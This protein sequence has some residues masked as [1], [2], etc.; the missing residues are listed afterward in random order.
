MPYG[1]LIGD[2]HVIS[3]SRE[4]AI[5]IHVRRVQQ[6]AEIQDIGAGIEAGNLIHATR[7]Q[8]QRIGAGPCQELNCVAT[9]PGIDQLIRAC[10]GYD[11][12]FS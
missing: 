10:D 12:R 2:R 1:T 7:V 8:D 11:A 4:A 3:Q 5:Q 6:R 9:H